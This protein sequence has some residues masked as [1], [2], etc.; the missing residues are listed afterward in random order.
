MRG[1]RGRQIKRLT[2]RLVG[3]DVLG[4]GEANP[5]AVAEGGGAAG[6]LGRVLL[7]WLVHAFAL[8]FWDRSAGRG[9]AGAAPSCSHFGPFAQLDP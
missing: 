9:W 8:L 6:H 4:N 5:G 1:G 2:G 7:T 3:D